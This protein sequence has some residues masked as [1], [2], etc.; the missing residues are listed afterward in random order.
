MPALAY[1]P[2][3]GFRSRN[4]TASISK[5]QDNRQELNK[6]NKASLGLFFKAE[7]SMCRCGSEMVSMEI[8][9]NICDTGL[10]QSLPAL[11]ASGDCMCT[12]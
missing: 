4:T 5:S 12:T 10:V 2:P 8:S 9:T 1:C 7:I 6:L 3:P 11:C